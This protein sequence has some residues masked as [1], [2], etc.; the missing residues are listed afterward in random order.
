M[1]VAVFSFLL[2]IASIVILSIALTKVVKNK[3][4]FLVIGNGPYGKA[5]DFGPP[6][7][8]INYG[9][10]L[11]NCCDKESDLWFGACMDDTSKCN[12]PEAYKSYTILG[13]GNCL[14]KPCPNGQYCCYLHGF[15]A[16][17]VNHPNDCYVRGGTIG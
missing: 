15:T 4:N 2:V 8:C 6:M 5:V 9:C 16:Q 10:T 14:D 17:C 11:G 3:E 12:D 7:N 13:Q 1:Y